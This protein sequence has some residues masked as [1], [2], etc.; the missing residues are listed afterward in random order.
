MEE[1]GKYQKDI[2]KVK[3]LL[4]VYGIEDVEPK[5]Q[6]VKQRALSHRLA[7]AIHDYDSSQEY[8]E[9]KKQS[10]KLIDEAN[11][12]DEFTKSF[13]VESIRLVG[14][15]KQNEAWAKGEVIITSN[16]FIREVLSKASEVIQDEKYGLHTKTHLAG[17]RETANVKRGHIISVLHFFVFSDYP[18][19]LGLNQSKFYSF[20]YDLLFLCKLVYHDDLK[21]IG[22]N[23]GGRLK[24]QHVKNWI[25]ADRKHKDI[26]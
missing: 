24:W 14:V 6:Q 10:W 21:E 4:E 3:E 26:W 9:I 12:I 7:E 1:L 23:N 5:E 13:K 8:L 22:Y 18:K 17:R 2:D 16:A 15:P 20:I 19:Y 11:K 25:A